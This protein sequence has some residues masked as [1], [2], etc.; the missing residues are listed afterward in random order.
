MGL[1]QAS[2]PE[3]HAL[4]NIRKTESIFGW[5]NWNPHRFSTGRVPYLLTIENS[6]KS[7]LVQFRPR[8]LCTRLL[9]VSWL[10]TDPQWGR[11]SIVTA[12]PERR[13]LYTVSKSIMDCL[14]GWLFVCLSVCPVCLNYWNFFQLDGLIFAP[15]RRHLQEVSSVWG[16]Y[17]PDPAVRNFNNTDRQ[18]DRLTTYS[19]FC[20]ECQRQRI[21][22][23]FDISEVQ[24]W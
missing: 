22:A 9:S 1:S 5:F 12:S 13:E 23:L 17:Q 24:W 20:D 11:R 6:D 4:N 7:S 19:Y 2:R 3:G 15:D 10:I 8:L 18:T 16:K 14:S 21:R